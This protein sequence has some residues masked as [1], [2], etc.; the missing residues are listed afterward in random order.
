M[1]E[2]ILGRLGKY[3]G[4]WRPDL[5]CSQTISPR[6][7][8]RLRKV[9]SCCLRKMISNICTIYVVIIYVYMLSSLI[10]RIKSISSAT[11]FCVVLFFPFNNDNKNLCKGSKC[12]VSGFPDSL[13][14]VFLQRNMNVYSKFVPS[15]NKHGRLFIPTD[16]ADDANNLGPI[17]E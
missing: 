6:N 10:F 3:R 8:D 9:G 1:C 11:D 17:N 14:E 4:C 15:P 7:I 2:H 12:V 5:P 13:S 16:Q